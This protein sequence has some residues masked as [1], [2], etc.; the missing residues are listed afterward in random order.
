MRRGSLAETIP[1][2]VEAAAAATETCGQDRAV[3]H[4]VLLPCCRGATVDEF[5][6]RCIA[7]G[8]CGS[9]RLATS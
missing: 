4:G 7:K 3:D 9:P 1:A 8:R 2:S 5:R 6:G